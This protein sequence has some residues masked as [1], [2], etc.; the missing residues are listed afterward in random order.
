MEWNRREDAGLSTAPEF[1]ED[2]RRGPRCSGS[3]IGRSGGG[4][5]SGEEE[6][7]ERGLGEMRGR[8][9]GGSLALE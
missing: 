9:G 7:L 8:D 5:S 1:G 6:R 2:R 3:K 4:F